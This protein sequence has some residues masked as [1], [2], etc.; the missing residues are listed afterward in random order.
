MNHTILAVGRLSESYWRQ[1]CDEYLK[2]L[3]RFGKCVV[4][5]LPEQRLGKRPSAAEIAQAVEVEGRAMLERLPKRAHICGLFVEGERRSSEQ[6]AELVGALPQE[7]HSEAVWLIG[8]SH[9]MS[10]QVA[11]A[12]QKKLSFS[13]LTFPHQLMRVLLCEQLYRAETIL[14]GMEYHK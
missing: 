12:C 4:L 5:E 13:E 7:G 8:G 2:R 14:A 6:L 9:G 1:A 10:A 3:G 11:A